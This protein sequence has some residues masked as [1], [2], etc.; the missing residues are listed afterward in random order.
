MPVSIPEQSMSA[1]SFPD[2][3]SPSDSSLDQ[4]DSNTPIYRID[5]S[6]FPKAIPILGPVFG[7]TDAKFAAYSQKKLE[8]ATQAVKRPLSQDEA[9]AL[10]Y[11]G[12]KQWSIMSYAA[13]LG[14]AGGLWR[15]WGTTSTFRFPFYQPDLD[16]KTRFENF[17]TT[18]APALKGLRAVMAWHFL[19]GIAYGYM[20][21]IVAEVFLG[22]YAASVSVVGEIG[23][24]RLRAYVEAVRDQGK[25]MPETQQQGQRWPR[26][27]TRQTPDIP[28]GRDD[29]SPTAGMFGQTDMPPEG[30]DEI[31][32][33]VTQRRQ[34]PIRPPPPQVPVQNTDAKPFDL[35]DDASPTAAQQ[36]M[37]QDTQPV[38][39][40]G[41]A[42]ERI[43]RGEKP[44]PPTMNTNQ[45]RRA[46]QMQTQ[47]QRGGD[48][49][50]F[51]K[52]DEE[53]SYAKEEA[54]KEFDARLERERR[55]GDF[56]AGANRKW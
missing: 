37:V 24:K 14:I 51:S 22:S 19:R 36:G 41:S 53:K 16:N 2:E 45:D 15:C 25:K 11:Y 1:D 5:S 46:Q 54:Q 55:G 56:N 50:T 20:G 34:W 18:K 30:D 48:G 44:P 26:P 23:D 21:K 10:L 3:V 43:R 13:P 27:Q 47:E 17:P 35:F 4:N 31:S 42:W 7:W 6:N 52:A 29:A 32:R 39:Q 40:Q 28:I 9:T 33:P 38:R 49:Y 8:K 12:A